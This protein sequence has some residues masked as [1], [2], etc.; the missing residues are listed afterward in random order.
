MSRC[1]L[2]SWLDGSTVH[3]EGQTTRLWFDRHI[4]VLCS[5]NGELTTALHMQSSSALQE[6]CV[7][8]SW[9]WKAAGFREVNRGKDLQ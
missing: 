3:R 2:K 7:G 9:G 5:G 6:M 4:V 1:P 8:S